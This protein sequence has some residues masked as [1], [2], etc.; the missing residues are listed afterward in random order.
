[1]DVNSGFDI[2]VISIR[3]L[4]TVVGHLSRFGSLTGFRLVLDD[5]FRSSK[6]RSNFVNLVPNLN[7]E[8]IIGFWRNFTVV[9]VLPVDVL[10]R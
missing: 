7:K 6:L 1:M 4:F 8:D 5:M 9:L 2:V 10:S 3:R